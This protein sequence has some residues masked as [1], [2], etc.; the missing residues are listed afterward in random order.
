MKTP[1]F[2]T[3][4]SAVALR[5]AAVAFGRLGEPDD[6]S[7][8]AGQ[9][10]NHRLLTAALAYADACERRDSLHPASISHGHGTFMFCVPGRCGTRSTPDEQMT[11]GQFVD[12][13]LRKAGRLP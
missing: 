2:N 12:A 11:L 8:I 4:P 1:A 10:A 3:H 9:V 13:A 5:E 6:L 7:D